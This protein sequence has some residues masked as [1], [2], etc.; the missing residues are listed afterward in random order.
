MGTGDL[1]IA[2]Q[3][4]AV[5]E[6]AAKSGD[7]EALYPLLAPDIE[8][9]M[10]VRTLQGISQVREQMIWGAPPEHLDQEFQMGD[11]IVL[12]AGQVACDVH[13]TYRTKKTG[14]FAYERDL[15]IELSIQGSKITRYEMRIVNPA[16][17]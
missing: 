15:R 1:E 8:W 16:R 11:W 12:G 14:E 9:V 3:F 13:Q 17:R 6:V 4:R 5:L 7:R 2:S 10:P